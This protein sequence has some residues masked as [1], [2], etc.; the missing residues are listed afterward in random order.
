MN[1]LLLL[2]PPLVVLVILT[3]LTGCFWKEEKWFFVFAGFVSFCLGGLGAWYSA[4]E[5]GSP[6]WTACYLTWSIC[7]LIALVRNQRLVKF[8]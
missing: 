2:V 1:S 4:M 8:P 7:G 6:E 5:S 3:T